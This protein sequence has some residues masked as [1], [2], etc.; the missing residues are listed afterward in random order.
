MS[1]FSRIAAVFRSHKLDQDIE[2]E[3][4]S[5]VEMRAEDNMSA[6]MSAEEAQ[7]NA[8]RRFGNSALIQESTRTERIALWLET[9]LQ[10]A[11]FA[12]RMLRRAPGFTIVAVLTVALS[13]GATAAV[14]T[15]VN[16]VLLRPLPYENPNRL[17]VIAIFMPRGNDE[18]TTSPQYAAFKDN[19]RDLEEAGAWRG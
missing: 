7:L 8:R 19:S 4:R 6:G 13:I 16:S 5:H 3:L 9:V 2:E 17:I 18:V 12:L 11:R 1:L 15:V 10:D 14:F